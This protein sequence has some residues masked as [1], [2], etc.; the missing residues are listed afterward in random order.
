MHDGLQA[1]GPRRRKDG[2]IYPR[3]YPS[4]GD[5]RCIGTKPTG[6]LTHEP[7]CRVMCPWRGSQL[8]RHGRM[9]FNE[10][11]QSRSRHDLLHLAAAHAS[12]KG[13]HMVQMALTTRNK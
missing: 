2:G 3:L 4:R 9:R 10:D 11:Q 1:S 7:D 8:L 5:E 13:R 12:G 6:M